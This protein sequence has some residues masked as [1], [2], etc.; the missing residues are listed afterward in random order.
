MKKRH[1]T[2]M[3][4]PHDENRVKEYGL[5]L[6]SIRGMC[7]VLILCFAAL[8]YFG[9]GY[10][11]RLNQESEFAM[12]EAE[13]RSL[14]TQM[15]EVDH[16]L[17]ELRQQ[18]T[19]LVSSDMR[20]R[21]MA[22]LLPID[23]VPGTNGTNGNGTNG[24]HPPAV[25]TGQKSMARK[26]SLDLENLLREAD[27][28]KG[29]FDEVATKLSKDIDIRDHTPSISP[30]LLSNAWI[31]S[32]FG[33]RRHPFT[34]KMHTHRGVD[35]SCRRGTH[36]FA[37]ADGIVSRR[38][39]DQELG[40]FI[41]IDHK[42]GLKTLYG[43]LKGFEVK[44]GQK[45]RRGQIIGYVGM[46][47]RATAPHVHYGLKKNGRWVNPFPYILD[48]ERLESNRALAAKVK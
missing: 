47:G 26:V 35:I 24:N 39:R 30:V 25:A 9:I 48:R 19:E 12:L 10:Y 41:E 40:K 29:S 28:V 4:I 15:K 34:G 14:A 31:S 11:I 45:V 6:R 2:L 44:R 23:D 42:Y 16:E 13:N 43:H 20:L 5:S 3:V 36:I 18:M 32:Q 46:T 38:K 21:Q 37:V 1:L 33:R 7:G 17:L 8:L 22:N 27:L